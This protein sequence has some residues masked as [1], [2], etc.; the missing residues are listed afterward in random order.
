[1]IDEETVIDEIAAVAIVHL[2]SHHIG[3][4]HL[5]AAKFRE[6]QGQ[7]ALPL[8]SGVIDDD[9]IPAAVLAGPGIGDESRPRSSCRT[10]RAA[11]GSAT[12]RRRERPW[13]PSNLQQPGIKCPNVRVRRLNWAAAEMG[14]HPDPRSLELALMEEAQAGREEGD[15][16]R[17][18][19]L[20]PG[21]FGRGARLV[22]VFEK[23]G[24]LVLVVEAGEQMIAD[25]P[26][27]RR[28]AGGR[29]AACRSNRRSPAAARSIRGPSRPR[30]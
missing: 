30:P 8:V 4:A 26:D 25:R 16:R 9:D 2:G 18:L 24:E 3:Q 7:P 28:L 17:R 11:A 10:R 19:V 21:K 13:S 23:A 14:R 12:T 15:D 27:V 22:V 1:M 29:R 20:R 6:W 5:P